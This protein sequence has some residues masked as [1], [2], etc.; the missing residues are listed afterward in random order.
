M[1]KQA[2]RDLV[3]STSR[4]LRAASAALL[5]AGC[6]RV[7]DLPPTLPV[8]PTIARDQLIVSSTFPVPRN[9]RLV[10][11]LVA[12]R[13]DL[14][15][16]LNLPTSD[17]PIHVY[18]FDDAQKF[19]AFLRERYPHFPARRAFFIETDTQLIVYAHWGGRVAEDLRHEVAHGYLHSVIS[20]LP[21]W[22]DEGLAEYFE[23][24]RG[25]HGVNRPHLESLSQRL[26]EGTF[27]PNLPRL[28]QIT[29]AA[30]LSQADY[31]EAWAWVHLLLEGKPDA[32][33]LLKGYLAALRR[34]GGAE[35]L[36]K[37]LLRL[38]PAIDRELVDHLRLLAQQPA[39]P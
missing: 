6:S 3:Q 10:E 34:E 4:L 18:L 9:H 29:D 39:P 2:S 37:A 25:R 5:V 1:S 24:P 21:L 31:A 7:H 11:E 15:S 33:P 32:T 20:N 26:A 8:Q 38:Y 30:Q 17:E 36:S 12:Q 23:V 13:Y 27:Q 35:P 19:N 28:E 16:K 22:L 14:S